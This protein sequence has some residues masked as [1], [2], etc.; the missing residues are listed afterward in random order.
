MKSKD[1]ITSEKWNPLFLF[2]QGQNVFKNKSFL[3]NWKKLLIE[4][5]KEY[6]EMSF[7]KVSP[8]QLYPLEFPFNVH[9]KPLINF[10]IP[11]KIP[12]LIESIKNEELS[13]ETFPIKVF[14]TKIHYD[15]DSA[16]QHF[17]KTPI[18]LLKEFILNGVYV[19]DGNTRVKYAKE[20]NIPTIQAYKI[21]STFLLDH[22]SCF[23]TAYHYASYCFLYDIYK[24]YLYPQKNNYLNQMDI[25]SE[26][27]YIKSTSKF[28]LALN[29]KVYF[30]NK[31]PYF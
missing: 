29:S 11:I 7:P 25:S 27:A 22:P 17:D 2:L 3:E 10:K 13:P 6:L 18:I 30:K 5:E 26:L 28:D 31:L 12:S 16:H 24:F 19:A 20:N 21:D 8:V 9:N 14:G 15:T 4:L 23:I 1:P